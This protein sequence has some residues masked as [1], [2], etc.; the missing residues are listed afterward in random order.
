MKKRLV[1]YLSALRKERHILLAA[2]LLAVFVEI[3]GLHR[4][5]LPTVIVLASASILISLL[6]LILKTWHHH[7]IQNNLDQE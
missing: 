2:I 4:F 1:S 6:T 7:R 5:I 3:F